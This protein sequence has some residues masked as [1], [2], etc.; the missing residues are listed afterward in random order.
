MFELSVSGLRC[1]E[2]LGIFGE[3]VENLP[4]S[5]RRAHAVAEDTNIKLGF[6]FEELHFNLC[7]HTSQV[8]SLLLGA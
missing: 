7:C 8:N 1:R 2:F 6:Q 3:S 4:T 5:E